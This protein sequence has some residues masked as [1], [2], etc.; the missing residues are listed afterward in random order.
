MWKLHHL[1]NV[2]QYDNALI[3][4][5][6]S[7]I[8]HKCY[9]VYS[10]ATIDTDTVADDM[11]NPAPSI[12]FNGSQMF[13]A[14]EKNL[15][16]TLDQCVAAPI[17]LLA[18][19]YVYNMSYPLGLNTFYAFLEYVLLDKK[20]KKMATCFSHFITYSSNICNQW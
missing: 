5:C 1:P 6:I 4:C 7:I 8:Q 17:A 20:P 13:M 16:C 11:A 12:I 19:Y 9:I 10:Q 2:S 15:I 14:A 18:A 3:Y